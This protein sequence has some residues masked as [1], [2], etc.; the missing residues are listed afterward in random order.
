MEYTDMDII[1]TQSPTPQAAL[2]YV[3]DTALINLSEGWVGTGVRP[4]YPNTDAFLEAMNEE[5]ALR[6]LAFLGLHPLGALSLI[7]LPFDSAEAFPHID[8]DIR[9]EHAFVLEMRHHL[10]KV[11]Y[12][13]REGRLAP[14]LSMLIDDDESRW[15]MIAHMYIREVLGAEPDEI[16]DIFKDC[17]EDIFRVFGYYAELYS[18]LSIIDREVPS[19]MLTAELS[20]LCTSMIA[21]ESCIVFMA[22]DPDADCEMLTMGLAAISHASC[23][24]VSNGLLDEVLY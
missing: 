2:D 1:Y 11:V 6:I 22:V 16:A 8:E 20:S 5:K 14:L 3:L 10:S 4:Q 24:K 21:Y 23:S 7:K 9:N 17:S 19:T 15:Q 13:I 18:T 12:E